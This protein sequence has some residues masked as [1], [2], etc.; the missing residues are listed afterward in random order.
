MAD[1]RPAPGGG[2]RAPLG[3]ERRPRVLPD[4]RRRGGVH[5]EHGE[6]E[7]H[8]RS[9]AEPGLGA[10]DAGAVAGGRT[11]G[12]LPAAARAAEGDGREE[13]A[14]EGGEALGPRPAETTG[15]EEGGGAGGEEARP[16]SALEGVGDLQEELAVL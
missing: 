4:V 2:G 16:P 3:Q 11:S 1:L 15:E 6:G 8:L 12:R 7:H 5:R 13:R 14:A 10:A 9:R